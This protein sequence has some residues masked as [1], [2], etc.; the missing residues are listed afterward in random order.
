MRPI[1][2]FIH[3]L[4]MEAAC[5]ATSGRAG[6]VPCRRVRRAL[7]RCKSVQRDARERPL[8]E[9]QDHEDLLD[10]LRLLEHDALVEQMEDPPWP[11][12]GPH[13]DDV[14]LRIIESMRPLV[15]AALRASL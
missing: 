12:D 6:P 10:D 13:D 3:H 2:G 9:Q 11:D 8:I 5:R 7:K 4:H 15:E 14:E 1:G